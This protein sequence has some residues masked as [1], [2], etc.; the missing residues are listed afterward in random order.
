MI[1]ILSH[2][3]TPNWPWI[4]FLENMN[5][6][7]TCRDITMNEYGKMEE[8]REFSSIGCHK[9]EINVGVGG[10]IK[11]KQFMNSENK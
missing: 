11:N 1:Y 7:E 8:G 4:K 2:G 9:N 10:K 6:R 3:G 5:L